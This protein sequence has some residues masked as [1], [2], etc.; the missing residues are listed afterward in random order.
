MPPPSNT[1]AITQTPTVQ[2]RFQIKNLQM[3]TDTTLKGAAV[4]GTVYDTQGQPLTGVKVT[5]EKAGVIIDATTDRGGSYF[6]RVPEPGSYSIIVGDNKNSELT[7]QLKQFDVANVDWTAIGQTS[8]MPL[9][10]A[11]IRTVD[12]LWDDSLTFDVAT[13]WD[14]ARFKWS[15]SGGELIEEEDGSVT[16]QPPEQPGRYL[17]QVVADWGH[18]GIAVDSMVLVVTEDESITFML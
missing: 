16:W 13:S 17:L 18:A 6:I 4:R 1:R 12:I 3:T 5:V 2:R 15:V 9:P 7:L 10:L 11:E 8:Q 14:D